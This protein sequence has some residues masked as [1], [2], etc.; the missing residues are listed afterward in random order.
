VSGARKGAVDRF[1]VEVRRSAD[2]GAVWV[3]E[4]GRV[5]PGC[6]SDGGASMSPTPVAWRDVPERVRRILVSEA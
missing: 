1:V 5:Y 3:W 4:G 2:S 6:V